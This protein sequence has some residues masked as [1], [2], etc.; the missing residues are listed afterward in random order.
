MASIS[1]GGICRFCGS[2]SSA[3]GLTSSSAKRRASACISSR[4]AVRNGSGTSG[5]GAGWASDD[6]VLL[7]PGATAAAI[8]CAEPSDLENLEVALLAK[9]LQPRLRVVVQLGNAALGRAV[10]RVIGPNSVLDTAAIA[11]PTL[12]EACLELHSRPIDLAGHAF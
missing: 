5:N 8:I 9:R 1:S 3:T 10:G 2:Y 11:A 6:T 7:I 12:A 4:R